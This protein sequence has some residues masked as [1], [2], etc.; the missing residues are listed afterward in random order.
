MKKRKKEMDL[1]EKLDNSLIKGNFNKN[2]FK[3]LMAT[4]TVAL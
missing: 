4:F 1:K 3:F 2:P